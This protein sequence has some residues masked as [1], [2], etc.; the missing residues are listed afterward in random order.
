[1]VAELDF[2]GAVP[3]AELTDSSQR[4]EMLTTQMSSSG[5]YVGCPDTCL[6][7]AL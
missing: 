4:A 6:R 1:L 2:A 3:K 7:A 5:Y